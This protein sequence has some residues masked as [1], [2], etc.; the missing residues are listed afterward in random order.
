MF[1]WEVNSERVNQFFTGPYLFS[2][3]YRVFK[4]A[5]FGH[6][7]QL[8]GKLPTTIEN[9]QNLFDALPLEIRGLILSKIWN[10]GDGFNS[11]I[12]LNGELILPP[13]LHFLFSQYGRIKTSTQPIITKRCGAWNG[14]QIGGKFTIRN[15]TYEFKYGIPNLKSRFLIPEFLNSETNNSFA[16]SYGLLCP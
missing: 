14:S 12:V 9:F 8:S 3:L 5:Y 1:P 11:L 4:G 10:N 2:A 13:I 6:G 16:I 7:F 15:R